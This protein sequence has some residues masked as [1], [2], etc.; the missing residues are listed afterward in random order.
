MKCQPPSDYAI[1][2]FLMCVLDAAYAIKSHL[3]E[4]LK[5]SAIRY[6]RTV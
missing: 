2:R 1:K 6:L 5:T 3:G 4:H